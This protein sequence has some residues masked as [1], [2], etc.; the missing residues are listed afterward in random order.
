MMPRRV[1]RQST[2]SSATKSTTTTTTENR[3]RIFADCPTVR[4]GQSTKDANHTGRALSRGS[5]HDN[6][7]EIR[8]YMHTVRA[9]SSQGAIRRMDS[10]RPRR[11][12]HRLLE[13]ER[14][15]LERREHGANASSRPRSV[16]LYALLERR[17]SLHQCPR[18]VRGCAVLR[19]LLVSARATAKPFHFS[20]EGSTP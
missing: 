20:H 19:L 18:P 11:L 3:S 8:Q 13:R 2:T 1:A 12:S 14:E 5:A 4:V 7:S 10:R 15:R 9:A 16:A 6:H 17:R